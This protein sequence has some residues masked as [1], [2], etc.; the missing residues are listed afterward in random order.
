MRTLQ[1]LLLITCA[2]LGGCVS[3]AAHYIET[4]G[5]HGP[6][7]ELKQVLLQ[8]TDYTQHFFTTR[9]GLRLAYWYS[10]PRDVPIK[11]T[12]SEHRTAGALRG[13]SFSFEFPDRDDHATPP[14]TRGSVVLL[15]PW[16]QNAAQMVFWGTRFSSAGYVTVLPTLRSQGESG[17]A[18]VGY[19]PREADDVVQLIDAL[20]AKHELPAPLYLFGYSYGATATLFAAPQLPDLRG[21][22][23]MAP[24]VHPAD[25]ILRAPATGWFAPKWWARFFSP[26]TMHK[27][28]ARADHKL[29]IDLASIDPGHALATSHACTLLLRG[30]D[31]ILISDDALKQLAAL[32][33]RVDYIDIP[34]EGHIT[35]FFRSQQLSP[36]II[37]WMQAVARNRATTCPDFALPATG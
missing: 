5:H 30:S 27:A 16:G 11:E 7:P 12:F 26:R 24:Y 20:Q 1:W 37:V 29:G 35:L 31:D 17:D 9:D 36:S 8:G 2:G 25:V 22:V 21:V 19:G 3:V 6:T 4:P 28:I 10:P 15:H 23:A 18:P 14:V 13:F 34:G 33:P 32:S